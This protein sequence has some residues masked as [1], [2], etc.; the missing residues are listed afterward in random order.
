MSDT[1][2]CATYS[3]IGVILS[4]ALSLC[5]SR[6]TSKYEASRLRLQWQRDN[7]LTADR[8]FSEMIGAVVH[9]TFFPTASNLKGEALTRV[10]SI[11]AT[12]IG[13]LAASL[14]ALSA[15]IASGDVSM[16]QQTLESAIHYKRE[17]VRNR[18]Y[19]ERP[20]P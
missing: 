8:E 15:S 7:D 18:Q 1:L 4:G 3:L 10:C 6:L 5:V 19:K 14:D 11:R 13:S 9:Y 16:I 2:L 20:Q 17:D 12:Q